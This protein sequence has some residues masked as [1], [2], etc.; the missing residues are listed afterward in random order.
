MVMW[1]GHALWYARAQVATESAIVVVIDQGVAI[2]LLG[3]STFK[4]DW[5]PFDNYA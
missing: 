4:S 3:S 2:D 1:E 5:L